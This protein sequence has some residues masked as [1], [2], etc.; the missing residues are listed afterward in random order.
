MSARAVSRILRD[1]AFL[2]VTPNGV[3]FAGPETRLASARRSGEDSD[4]R[5]RQDLRQAA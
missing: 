3:G 5:R 4:A 2:G 1:R